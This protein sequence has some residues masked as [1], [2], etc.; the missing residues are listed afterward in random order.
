V[1]C[2]AFEKGLVAHTVTESAERHDVDR[3]Y[4]FERPDGGFR[5]VHGRWF[6]EGFVA[7]ARACL[8]DSL[9]RGSV[10][11]RIDWA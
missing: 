5:V 4:A 2:F 1:T 11:A 6:G 8:T 9:R 7:L 10:T 3:C